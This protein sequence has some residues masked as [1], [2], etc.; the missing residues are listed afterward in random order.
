MSP[1]LNRLYT[2]EE[3]L[4]FLESRSTLSTQKPPAADET[5]WESAC[6]H[7]SVSGS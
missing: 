4:G 1:A 5:G 3:M 7:S 2:T 6:L